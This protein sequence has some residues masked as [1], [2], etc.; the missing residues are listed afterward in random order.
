VGISVKEEGVQ[1]CGEAAGWGEGRERKNNVRKN[2]GKKMYK[3]VREKND[4]TI[5]V[6]TTEKKT[7]NQK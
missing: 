3:Q 4:K 1:W 7:I 5:L 2:S 6:T